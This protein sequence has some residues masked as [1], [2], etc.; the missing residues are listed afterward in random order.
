MSCIYTAIRAVGNAAWSRQRYV[1]SI[2]LTYSCGGDVPSNNI[3][4]SARYDDITAITSSIGWRIN[5]A[6]C[7]IAGC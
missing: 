4:L 6:G 7:N 2:A 5:R 1:T 3:A